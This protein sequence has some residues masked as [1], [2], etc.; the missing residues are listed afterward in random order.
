MKAIILWLRIRA[1]QAFAQGQIDTMPLV[2]CE[3]TRSRMSL[4]HINTLAEIDRLKAE[5]R[6]LLRG[7]GIQAVIGGAL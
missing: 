7:S 1:L 5:R 3:E 2:C 6:K 4:A